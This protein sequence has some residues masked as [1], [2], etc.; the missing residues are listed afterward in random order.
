MLIAGRY[1]QVAHA[2]E[3]RWAPTAVYKPRRQGCN[4][5]PAFASRM[6]PIRK[7]LWPSK[8]GWKGK[9]AAADDWPWGLILEPDSPERCVWLPARSSVPCAAS[10]VALHR[11][12]SDPSSGNP[13]VFPRLG[14]AASG[15]SGPGFGLARESKGA[16]GLLRPTTLLLSPTT[17]YYVLL[18]GYE[19]YR[20]KKKKHGRLPPYSVL[21][22]SRASPAKSVFLP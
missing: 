21:R 9:G 22:I 13:H 5:N 4:A 18:R 2:P 15:C 19:H 7:L 8:D 11:R 14:G 16:V 6:L 12:P 10:V 3:R 1:P 17:P 20:Q